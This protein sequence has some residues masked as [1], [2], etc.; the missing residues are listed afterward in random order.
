MGDGSSSRFD[1]KGKRPAAQNGDM[2]ALNLDAAEEGQGGA[3]NGGAFM[4]MQL[5]E[6]QVRSLSLHMPPILTEP[7]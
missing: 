6:Q 3:P 2:L 1:P 5:V 4:Q 7:L